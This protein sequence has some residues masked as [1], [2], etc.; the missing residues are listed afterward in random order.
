MIQ[1]GGFAIKF[2]EGT[3]DVEIPSPKREVKT[4]DSRVLAE[5]SPQTRK[6]GDRDYVLEE[7]ITGNIGLGIFVSQPILSGTLDELTHSESLESGQIRKP[8][9]LSRI[10]SAWFKR[11]RLD[12]PW[13]VPKL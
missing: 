1:D 12:I 10:M 3:K 5:C 7:S 8:G 13:N 2:K 4:A 11:S 9:R 6:F